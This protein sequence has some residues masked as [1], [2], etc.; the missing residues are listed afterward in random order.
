MG[1]KTP[2]GWW[3]EL[4]EIVCEVS[5]APINIG[6]LTAFLTNYLY[7]YF[8]VELRSKKKLGRHG[9]HQELIEASPLRGPG[10]PSFI[11]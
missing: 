9:K 7:S 3:K 5:L 8:P 2:P 4:N 11:L 6:N 10:L 1:I